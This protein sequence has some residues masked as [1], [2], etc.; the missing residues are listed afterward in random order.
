MTTKLNDLYFDATGL[1]CP[2]LFVK[3]KQQLK[4][5]T[6]HQCLYVKVDDQVGCG[7]IKKYLDKHD[8][9]YTM[10]RSNAPVIEF[11]ICSKELIND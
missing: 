4:Q 10:N 5:L 9:Q 7:D 8:Y 1:K 6:P 11:S 3:T 2:L